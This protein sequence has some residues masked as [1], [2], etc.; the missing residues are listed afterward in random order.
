MTTLDQDPGPPD[1]STMGSPG[2]VRAVYMD[3]TLQ[4][5]QCLRQNVENFHARRHRAAKKLDEQRS[6]ELQ[7]RDRLLDLRT[8]LAAEQAEHDKITVDVG[9]KEKLDKLRGEHAV[10]HATHSWTKTSLDSALSAQEEFRKGYAGMKTAFQK[11][12]DELQRRRPELEVVAAAKQDIEK[13][14]GLTKSKEVEFQQDLKDCE[15]SLKRILQ[16][17]K[18]K[19]SSV[20]D[21]MLTGQAC[22]LLQLTVQGWSKAS[23]DAKFWRSNESA[24]EET[25]K[26]LKA[27]QARKRDHAKRVLE[28]LSSASEAGLAR[29]MFQYWLRYKEGAG[30]EKAQAVELQ[31][32]LKGQKLEAR[33]ALER[34]LGATA[35]A[36]AKTAFGDWA[37]HHE[38]CKRVS[39]LKAQAE[40]RMKECQ[41]RQKGGARSLLERLAGQRA[42]DLVRKVFLFWGVDAAEERSSR[43]RMEA[44]RSQADSMEAVL[45]DLRKD[46]A[47]KKEAFD[48]TS[49]EIRESRRKN[50][51]LQEEFRSILS[52]Q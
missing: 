27:L 7:L 43:K 9:L 23:Q 47:Q 1:G 49:E 21:K 35:T 40:S 46:L 8:Q 19:C 6:T 34:S 14:R 32:R 42:Q 28:R 20:L 41:T 30:R 17:Q 2:K 3:D 45:R 25:Q 16:R 11:A 13:T 37:R 38:E 31:A 39:E 5:A 29:V 15:E 10:L 26:K 48:D 52:M 50:K 4:D 51:V 12:S 18:K 36:R 24:L 22:T 44:L 33:R